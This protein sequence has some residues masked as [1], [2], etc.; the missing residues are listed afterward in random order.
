MRIA[1]EG[2]R[3]S[4]PEKVKAMQHPEWKLKEA[5]RKAVA[6]VEAIDFEGACQALVQSL[7][8]YAGTMGRKITL[9][10]LR[11]GFLVASRSRCSAV[12]DLPRPL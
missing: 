8:N 9:L 5:I 7:T 3:D 4:V 12:T 1:V 6:Q 11:Y 2:D 10:S